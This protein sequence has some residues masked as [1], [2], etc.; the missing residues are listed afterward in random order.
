MGGFNI[1]GGRFSVLEDEQVEFD[2]TDEIDS[3]D[4]TKK[5]S[6][7][8]IKL[9][10]NPITAPDDIELMDFLQ[11]Y[12]TIY[13]NFDFLLEDET[14]FSVE[15][16][17]T[18]KPWGIHA[19]KP[20]A[21]SS[22]EAAVASI[23]DDIDIPIRFDTGD[24]SR[25]F[26]TLPPHLAHLAGTTW[27][28]LVA[29]DIRPRV[30]DSITNEWL[31]IDSGAMLTVYPRSR[32][33]N[34]EIDENRS[35][36]AINRSRI[37]TYGQTA[38]QIRIGRKTYNHIAI[39]ADVDQPVLGWDFCKKYLLSL[40]WNEWGD[41]ELWDPK[42]KIKA[43]LQ[44]SSDRN[45]PRL[46]G[47]AISEHFPQSLPQIS[48]LNE[49]FA[50]ESQEIVKSFQQWSALQKQ[51]GNNENDLKAVPDNYKALLSKY[52]SILDC[53]FKKAEVRHGVVH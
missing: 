19:S 1:S 36:R 51:K 48:A 39:I 45:G 34:A 49:L 18:S 41:L 28:G 4:S 3:L 13:T 32:Y 52:P 25:R 40:V 43:P 8:D 33:S 53:D 21:Q 24:I 35:I 29:N 23:V 30:E 42:A 7:H 5:K 12:D 10:K 38:I 6:V 14:D 17:P 27:Q 44:M 9:N 2:S 20:V 31:L 11:K 15:S 37:H 16:M 46:A 50:T 47:C 22:W 26:D